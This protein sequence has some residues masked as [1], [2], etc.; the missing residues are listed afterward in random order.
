MN[1]VY[2]EQ[3]V[4]EYRVQGEWAD[5]SEVPI[6]H[7]SWAHHGLAVTGSG[8]L[9]GFHAGQLVFFDS[10]GRVVRAAETGLTEGHGITAVREG[11]D[12]FLWISDPGF[13]FTCDGGD[14]D[15]A[16]APLFG[17]GIRHSTREPR[18][19]EVNLAGEVVAEL[20]VPPR[21][22]AWPPSM[23]GAYCPCGT[24][25]DEQRFGGSGDIWVAD[26]Y[27]SGVVHR[28]DRN[29]RHLAALT[30]EEGG[31]RFACPHAVFI[32]RR[33]GKEPELY[34][35]D[36][37]NKRVQVYD[38]EG[39][40]LRTFGE[41]R[42]SSPSGFAQWG[43]LLVVAELYE[44]LALF[45]G[46]DNF[47]GYIGDDSPAPADR[48]WPDRPGWP[49]ALAEDG[50]ARVPGVPSEGRF[51]SPHAVAVDAAGNLYVAEWLLGG[52]Y[53]KLAVRA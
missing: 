5:L 33:G 22:P 32:D 10:G 38:L 49:N 9:V 13:V 51:N 21:D 12:E 42:L 29:R 11:E 3:Q 34:I 53:T 31:G 52:R 50:H 26:G 15:E 45:D 14:G 28:F 4:P 47:V 7:A 27:G 18:V 46:R 37:E 1:E 8:E 39:R 24:A 43:Q 20:P 44:R 19:V 48:G 25:V 40:F 17:K 2:F 23:M 6:A 36:R 41:Q 16:W 30:G 35:A